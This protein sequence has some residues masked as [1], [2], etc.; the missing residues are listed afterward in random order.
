MIKS[1]ALIPLTQGLFA[2]VDLE[3]LEKVEKFNWFAD[4][5]CRKDGSILAYAVRNVR[6]PNGKW[7]KG[8]MHRLVVGAEKGQHC[9]H[10]SG[11]GLD[12]RKDNV[13]ICTHVQNH[14]NLR[15]R[16]GGS[17]RHKGV[18]WNKLRG[19]WQAQITIN[20]KWRHLGYHANEDEAARAYD[21][22]AIQYFGEFARLNF[23]GERHAQ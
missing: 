6:L 12:N 19:K 7:T 8:Y 1:F 21:A 10:I 18:Y 14:Q 22:A 11:D 9:D 5:Y 3:D 20:G 2:T 13:R 16:T 4:V 17:S 15:T 23:P